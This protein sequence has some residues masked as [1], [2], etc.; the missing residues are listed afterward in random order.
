MKKRKWEY[1]IFLI[2]LY[3]SGFLL[4]LQTQ[5]LRIQNKQKIFLE[6]KK[7]VG[8]LKDTRKQEGIGILKIP[9]INLVQNF[10]SLED[11]RNTVE[12]NVTLLKGSTYPD[13]PQSKLYLAAH[14]GTGKIA[15]FEHLDSL[16]EGDFFYIS[17]QK[18]QYTYQIE[19]IKREEK[20]GKITIPVSSEKQA[21]LTTCDPKKEKMQLIVIA[22]L[23]KET[24][25]T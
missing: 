9:K 21:I 25:S 15:Y 10:Y 3:G 2:L 23:K 22:S 17:Y 12:Q 7:N 5:P 18:K 1:S 6:E 24:G 11:K 13:T 16:K 4:L 20:T 8:N 14:S 19:T